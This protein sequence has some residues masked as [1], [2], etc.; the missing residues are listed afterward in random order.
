MSPHMRCQSARFYGVLMIDLLESLSDL[1]CRI[2]HKNEIAL[3]K[4]ANV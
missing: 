2:C 1:S 3:G 4:V